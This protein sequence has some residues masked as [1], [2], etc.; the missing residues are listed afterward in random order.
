ME[1]ASAVSVLATATFFQ[2]DGLIEQAA[3][4]MRSTINVQT[5]ARFLDAAERYGALELRAECRT[6]LRVN[7]L[8]HMPEHPDRLRKVPADLL[9][10]L[11]AAPD[12]F[13]MQTEFSVYVLLR[14]WAFLQ[15]NR[16]W[17]GNPQDAVAQS[18]RFFRARAEQNPEGYFLETAEGAKFAQLFRKLRLSHLVHHHRDLEML[19]TDRI[20]PD[21]WMHRVYRDLW[22]TLLLV[23]QGVDRGAEETADALEEAAFDRRSVRCGRTL[24]AS[25]AGQ[26]HMWRWTGFNLGLD[27]IV[28]LDAKLNL[29]LKRNHVSALSPG[30]GEHEALLDVRKWRRV[31][32]KVSAACVN[33]QRQV[34]QVASSGLKVATLARNGSHIMLKLEEGKVKYPLLLAFNF[35]VTS[36]VCEDKGNEDEEETLEGQNLVPN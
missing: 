33:E 10:S 17:I 36:S 22:R 14:L 4:V 12:L 20:V 34:V 11:V 1:P 31:A 25:G 13:V 7:L 35:G 15:L 3:A 8:S 29:T 18:Q 26:T 30:G 28:T 16:H 6:W 27:L 2:L 5:V 19:V 24:H 32:Y 21:S 23:D 9:Q